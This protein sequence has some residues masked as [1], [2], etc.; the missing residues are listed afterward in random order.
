MPTLP[1]DQGWRGD[2]VERVVA[3]GAFLRQRA[4]DA[5]RSVASAHVLHHHGVTA[6]DK[7]PIGG[8]EI[9]ALSVR[10]ANE[11]GRDTG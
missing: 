8:G 10:R 7:R 1:S 4:E 5:F 11:H 2:P 9:G 6:F 3:V